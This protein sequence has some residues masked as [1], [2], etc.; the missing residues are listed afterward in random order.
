DNRRPVDYE[1]RRRLLDELKTRHENQTALVRDL[2]DNMNDGRIKL[3]AL[4]RSLQCRRAHPGLFAEGEYRPATSIGPRAEHVFGFVRR[5]GN[6][7]AVAAV[8][9]LVTR[10]AP[11]L[12]DRPLGPSVWQ[13]TAL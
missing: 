6:H 1:M 3:F 13:T 2:V 4:E 12:G 7:W 11:Q 8:P 5:H 10:L 9:R